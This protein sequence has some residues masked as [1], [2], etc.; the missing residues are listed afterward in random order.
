MRIA[1][2][3][4]LISGG[5]KREA[6]EL[7]RQFVCGGHTVD[8]YCPATADERFLPLSGLIKRRYTF[9]LRLCPEVGLRLPGVRKYLDVAGLIANLREL[10]RTCRKVA[11][12]IDAGSYDFVFVHH[13]RIV[14]SPYLLRY[15][16]TP[17]VYYCAEPM[18]EFYEPAIARPFHR[19][20]STIDRLQQAWYAPARKARNSIIKSE[21]RK[22]IRHASLLLTNSFFSAESIYR[23]YGLRARVVYLGV[24]TDKFRPLDLARDSFVLSVGAVGPLKGYDF[25]IESLAK[26]PANERPRLIVVG[27]TSSEGERVFLGWL[28]ADRGVALDV[29]ANVGEEELV[30][31]YNRA[32]V[33]VY[34]PVLEPFGLAP[35]EAMACGTP[36][37]AVKEGGVRESVA[38]GAVG[39][40]VER[41]A[42]SFAAALSDLLSSE[43]K[44][45]EFGRN[46][47]AHVESFWTWE[48][49][50][51]R[52]YTAVRGL[53]RN[54]SKAS[55]D[56][57]EAT[58]HLLR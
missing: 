32:L 18:R 35:L 7:A 41:V 3:H 8:L 4:N 25:I 37:V 13:D 30:E 20:Q 40:L 26:M 46:A 51:E 48:Q 10:K 38:D 54:Q 28:A 19:P 23:A 14:Q 33:F 42:E 1:L 29:F 52:F 57:H 12:A 36:V 45:G 15:L 6:Y 49:A 22:N 2:Y 17:S 50:A 31:L 16:K 11:S 44:R 27:N 47:R 55:I 24:D 56:T 53:T 21:D 58:A 43:S 34:S 39:F 9:D 5:S